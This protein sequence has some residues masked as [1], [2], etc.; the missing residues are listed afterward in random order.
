MRPWKLKIMT[1]LIQI[2]SPLTHLAHLSKH[3]SPR[4]KNGPNLDPTPWA[5]IN[6]HQQTLPVTPETRGSSYWIL[7]LMLFECCSSLKV[8]G[9][10]PPSQASR[11]S[12]LGSGNNIQV[13]SY[14]KLGSRISE[15]GSGKVAGKV[16][17]VDQ[18]AG[19]AKIL[20]LLET[21]LKWCFKWASN[22]A[23][24]HHFFPS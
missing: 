3:R 13:L 12:H 4:R 10:R 2:K 11:P 15:L 19:P 18:Y 16:L 21:V 7:C 5:I 9:S 8:Q 23:P 17:I 14:P 1:P 22:P 24:G 20:I 6:P